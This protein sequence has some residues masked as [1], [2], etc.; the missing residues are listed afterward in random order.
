MGHVHSFDPEKF[1]SSWWENAPLS[2]D[3]EEWITNSY[4][5]LESFWKEVFAIH[6][7]K[8]LLS[9]LGQ[10][11]DF[12]HDCIIR[13]LNSHDFAFTTI[14]ADDDKETW[15]YKKTSFMR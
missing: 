3:V 15:S 11:Y 12:Y 7:N 8:S 5:K 9:Q 10:Q 14:K 2:P 13:H 4:S 1:I 6:Q